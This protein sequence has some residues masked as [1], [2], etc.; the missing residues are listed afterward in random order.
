MPLGGSGIYTG[1]ETL[2]GE[3]ECSTQRNQP[4]QRP[5]GRRVLAWVNCP[6]SG[7]VNGGD[8]VNSR[9]FEADCLGSSPSSILA[10]MKPT[11]LF[12]FL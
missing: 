2:A 12:I 11:T 9:E 10:M 3:V 7:G 8:S 5:G 6:S 4:R 1:L